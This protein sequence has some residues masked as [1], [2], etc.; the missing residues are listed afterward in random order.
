MA[1]NT[2]DDILEGVK[3]N[4][5]YDAT[6]DFDDPLTNMITAVMAQFEVYANLSF[7]NVLSFD[8]VQRIEGWSDSLTMRYVP[9]RSITSFYQVGDSTNPYIQGTDFFFIPETG[10][11][12]IPQGLESGV[13]YVAGT[14]GYGIDEDGGSVSYPSDIGFA[15]VM[16]T[17]YNW[18]KRDNLNKKQIA[19]N[20]AIGS[21]TYEDAWGLL[22]GVKEILDKHVVA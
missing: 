19:G 1:Y 7:N 9:L 22:P 3:I 13:Y 15:A 11:I 12:Y 5:K 18:Q 6:G 10:I 20:T 4:L 17:T 14:Y 16:Q 8:S 2:V 21:I